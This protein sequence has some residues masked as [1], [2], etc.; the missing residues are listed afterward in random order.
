MMVLRSAVGIL[1]ISLWKTLL[2]VTSPDFIDTV[3]PFY[4]RVKWKVKDFDPDMLP[5]EENTKTLS[6]PSRKIAKKVIKTD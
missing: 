4:L 1:M 3:K 2:F 6:K 5:K